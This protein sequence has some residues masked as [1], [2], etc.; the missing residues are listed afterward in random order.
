MEKLNIYKYL[1][2]TYETEVKKYV[3][4]LEVG[5]GNY[6]YLPVDDFHHIF[7]IL[8]GGVKLGSY[9]SAGDEVVYDVLG[10]SRQTVADSMRR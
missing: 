4:N 1:S 8:K 9:S 10:A 6:A 7:E 2:Q 3:T 5:T